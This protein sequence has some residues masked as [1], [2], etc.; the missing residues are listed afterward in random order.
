MHY[1]FNP[2]PPACYIGIHVQ[3][4]VVD[5][6]EIVLHIIQLDLCYVVTSAQ[7]QCEGQWIVC[8]YDE[9]TKDMND[10]A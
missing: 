3:H 1:L 10:M 4:L 9:R 7:M 2:P 5:V 8:A 6:I